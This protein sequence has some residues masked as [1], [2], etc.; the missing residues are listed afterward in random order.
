MPLIIPDDLSTRWT[1]EA[2]GVFLLDR[3][4]AAHQDCRPPRLLVIDPDTSSGIPGA[5]P[6]IDRLLGL[7]SLSP[8]QLEPVLATLPGL[9]ASR[10]ALTA[11]RPWSLNW[12]DSFDAVIVADRADDG[13]APQ[14]SVCWDELRDLIDW[15]ADHTRAGL[16]LGSSA[17]AALA[18]VHGVE[19][20]AE[21]A[22]LGQTVLH[23][24]VRR[25][26]YL[27]RGVEDIFPIDVGWR[28]RLPRRLLLD[29]PALELLA[30]SQEGDPF[31]L[32]T[33]DRR[34]VYALHQPLRGAGAL[35]LANWLNFHLYQLISLP[36]R[37]LAEGH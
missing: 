34:S 12:T 17:A 30:T 9:P 8:L 25:Q 27:L 3:A 35:I 24:V 11:S 21:T 5:S 36:V 1:L 37:T 22:R 29:I 18:H 32:R 31:L 33:Y 2:D 7:L 26:S 4:G 10:S 16:Y 19:A 13:A 28:R 20:Q 6:V 23:S 14:D 15:A